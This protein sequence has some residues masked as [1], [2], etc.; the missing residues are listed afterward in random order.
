MNADVDG[1]QVN[2]FT[3]SKERIREIW[4][5]HNSRNYHLNEWMAQAIKNHI[6]DFNATGIPR[7]IQYDI[8]K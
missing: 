4:S 1:A 2:Y 7:D 8:L 5:L 3:D 6:D